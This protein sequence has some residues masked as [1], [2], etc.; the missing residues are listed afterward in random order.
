MVG[1]F[2]NNNFIVHKGDSSVELSKLANIPCSR[3]E[4]GRDIIQS[5]RAIINSMEAICLS[6]GA[7]SY[8]LDNIN[9]GPVDCWV[10]TSKQKHEIIYIEH[11]KYAYPQRMYIFINTID[12]ITSSFIKSLYENINCKQ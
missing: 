6:F 12:H 4:Y 11:W 2:N 10:I 3:L 5:G 1:V 8:T 7:A 9:D